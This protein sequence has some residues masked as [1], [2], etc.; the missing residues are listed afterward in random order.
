MLYQISV[1]TVITRI[2]TVTADSEDQAL[3]LYRNPDSPAATERRDPQ[4]GNILVNL[5][6]EEDDSSDAHE[7][8]DEATV[9]EIE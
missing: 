9:E 5:T 1:P 6:F 3:D 2:Y 4:S 8:E 7:I